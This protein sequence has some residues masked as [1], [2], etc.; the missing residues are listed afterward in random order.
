MTAPRNPGTGLDLLPLREHRATDAAPVP[1]APAPVA[2][3]V[4]PVAP[5]RADTP[6]AALRHVPLA[7]GCFA[8]FLAVLL[9]Y[10]VYPRLAVLPADPRQTQV[11]TDP[12]GTVLMVDPAAPA[13][14]KV[15]T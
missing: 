2:P 3:P 9:P 6:R 10:F 4:A 12:R 11:Q 15:L 5:P 8:L 1:P 7:A 13:G 14:A